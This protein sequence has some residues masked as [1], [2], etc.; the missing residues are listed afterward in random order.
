MTIHEA[1]RAVNHRRGFT[2]VEVI[3]VLAVLAVLA[4]IAI[5]MAL[6]IFETA[7]EDATREEMDNLKKAIIGD[8][9][10]LQ[11]SFR[12]DFGFLGDTGC[13]PDELRRV[14]NNGAPA[15]PVWSFDTSKQTGAGWKGPYITGATVGDEAEEYLKDQ[16]GN[17]YTYAPSSSPSPTCP[18]DATLTSNGPD[19]QPSTSDDIT[20]AILANE[21]TA[22]VRGSVK[23]SG[24]NPLAGVSVDV[25][26][27]SGGAPFNQTVTTDS[28]GNYSAAVPFGHRSVQ[29]GS[30]AGTLLFVPGSVT[31][32]GMVNH[33]VEFD[34]TNS[35][36]STVTVTHMTV[37]C[38][39]PAAQNS[40]IEIDGEIVSPTNNVSCGTQRTLQNDPERVF[41]G[42]S[43]TPAPLRVVA[44][45]PDTQLPDLIISGGGGQ[46]RRIRLED[47]E[48][49]NGMNQSMPGATITVTFF[50][51]PST[52]ITAV[53]VPIP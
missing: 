19:G 5:P 27:A 12:S 26:Y 3:V 48:Q 21:T 6:K 1:E 34:V 9:R 40:D 30:S 47:F 24:G 2:L 29:A 18:L 25:N 15:L 32:S 20:V 16:L 7:A 53:T 23:D 42:S 45:S 37:D 36:S 33:F 51:D 28:N 11:S 31:T 52:V 38:T 14:Y 17:D 13:L 43:T 49:S 39:A 50:S 10:K 44:D 4:A 46:T 8:T 41:A 35:S 22:T